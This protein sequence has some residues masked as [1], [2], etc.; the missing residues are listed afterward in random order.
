MDKLLKS[1]KYLH[2]SHK[3]FDP[4][5]IVSSLVAA[6][7]VF[8]AIAAIKSPVSYIDLRG[9]LIVVGGTFASICFQYDLQTIYYSIKLFF[10]TLRGTPEKDLLHI[11]QQ[12][13]HAILSDKIL[14][15]LRSG[16]EINGELLNDVVHMHRQGLVFEEIDEFITAKI[17]DDFLSREVAVNLL[18]KASVIAPA[19]GLFGTV[20]GLIGVL[21]TLSQ[22]SQ[23]GPSMSLALMTTAYG[24]ALSSLVFTPLAGRIE[25]HNKIYLEIHRQ[26]L[27]K[28][29]IVLNRENRRFNAPAVSPEVA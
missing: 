27:S 18:N 1:K 22:P 13:D 11:L 24:A 9:L 25:H 17:K 7:G 19:L 26:L 15:D 23:I 12:L 28:V 14:T 20:I 21:K 8:I 6:A 10:I 4:I 5:S 29:A 2:I 3:R 16:E